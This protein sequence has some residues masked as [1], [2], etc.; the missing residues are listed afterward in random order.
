MPSKFRLRYIFKPLIVRIARSLSKIKISPNMATGI[1]LFNA[2]I[3]FLFLVVFQNL[4]LFAIFVFITGIF[5]GVDGAIARLTNTE[6]TFGGFFDSFMDR[7]SEFIIFLALLIYFWNG[8]FW[9]LD[10]NFIIIISFL[11]SIMFSYSRA[12]AES[13]IKGDYDVGLMARSER[14]FYIFITMMIAFFI[15]WEELFLFVF[16]VLTVFSA[17]YRGIY[18]YNQIKKHTIKKTD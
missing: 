14:L 1:M 15:G 7:I 11:S 17:I 13:L 10:L 4:L 16:M 3:S 5:D 6:S 12:R 9:I 18:I 8:T 2:L